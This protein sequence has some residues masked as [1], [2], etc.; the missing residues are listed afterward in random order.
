M[1]KV[2]LSCG[3]PVGTNIDGKNTACIV[4]FKVSIHVGTDQNME[5]DNLA[6][7]KHTLHELPVLIFFQYV[8]KSLRDMANE[9]FYRK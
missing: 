5:I 9:S 1:S 2:I 6:E 8:Y 4:V 7:Y 3:F